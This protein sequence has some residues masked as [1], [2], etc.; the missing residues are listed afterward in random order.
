MLFLICV[1]C[2]TQKMASV[3]GVLYAVGRMSVLVLEV[4]SACG[5]GGAERSLVLVGPC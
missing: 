1:L 2:Y 3:E 5:P 4:V